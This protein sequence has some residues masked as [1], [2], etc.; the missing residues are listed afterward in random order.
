MNL[1]PVFLPINL[2]EKVFLTGKSINFLRKCCFE[3]YKSETPLELPKLRDLNSM[4][5]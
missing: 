2:V 5:Q 1:V 4:N 3:E